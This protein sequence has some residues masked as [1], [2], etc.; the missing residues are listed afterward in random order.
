MPNLDNRLS[1][2]H[3]IH[4]AIN[5]KFAEAGIVIA[6]PQRDIHIRTVV[7]SPQSSLPEGKDPLAGGTM[8]AEPK[9]G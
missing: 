1:I 5:R 6:F 2:N 8:T 4:E 3:E 7:E 9:E